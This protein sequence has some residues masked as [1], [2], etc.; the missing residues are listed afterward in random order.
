MFICS[1]DICLPI[2]IK[3]AY[4]A[5]DLASEQQNIFINSS[6]GQYIQD[7]A[8]DT[9]LVVTLCAS[10]WHLITIGHQRYQPPVLTWILQ[11]SDQNGNHDHICPRSLPPS[12]VLT[13]AA[14]PCLLQQ[15]LMR[16]VPERRVVIHTFIPR[17]KLYF[18]SLR[19][20]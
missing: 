10:F 1:N 2:Q 20:S 15:V 4:N 19:N 18:Q 3:T 6:T 14:H 16:R 9:V 12:L 13:I 8:L 5:Q 7:I 17:N 11:E